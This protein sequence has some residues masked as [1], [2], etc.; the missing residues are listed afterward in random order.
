MAKTQFLTYEIHLRDADRVAELQGNPPGETSTQGSGPTAQRAIIRAPLGAVQEFAGDNGGSPLTLVAP[1]DP[2]PSG[3]YLYSEWFTRGN[4]QN[5]EPFPLDAATFVRKS[6]GWFGIPLLFGQTTRFYWRGVFVYDAPVTSADPTNPSGT[7]AAIAKRRWI[8]PFPANMASAPANPSTGE[9]TQN[10]TRD[11]GRTVDGFGIARRGGANLGIRQHTL[12][13][14]E[15]FGASNKRDSWERIY[16]RLRKLGSS[17]G[18]IWRARGSAAATSG[19][20]LVF[21]AAGQIRA[22]NIDGAGATTDIA[23]T[24]ALEIGRW[25]KLDVIL[26]FATPA[27]LGGKLLLILDGTLVFD[28]TAPAGVGLGAEQFH[29]SSE[30]LTAND[31]DFEFDI[32]SWS[33]AAAPTADGV[34]AWST[35]APLALT[36]IDFLNGSKFVLVRATG[37]AAGHANWTGD[38]SLVNQ[39][40][41]RQTPGN[42]AAD[43]TNLA[44]SSTTAQAPMRLTTDFARQIAQPGSLG[45]ASFLITHYGHRGNTNGKIGYSLDGGAAVTIDMDG[46]AAG[47][48]GGAI[49]A[50]AWSEQLYAPSGVTTP[51]VVGTLELVRDKGND[52]VV[53]RTFI[54]QAVVELVGNFGN[55]DYDPTLPEELQYPLPY[56]GP[57]NSPYPTTPWARTVSP[58]FAPV[59]IKSGTYVGNGTHTD[60]TFRAPVN[61]IWIRRSSNPGLGA[62][63]AV[64]WFSSMLGAAIGGHKTPSP[65]YMPE[66]MVDPNFTTTPAEDEQAMQTIV[67]VSGDD[68][69]SNKNGETYHYIAVSDPGARFLLNGTASAR[70]ASMPATHNLINSLFTPIAAMFYDQK[71]ANDFSLAMGFKGEGHSANQATRLDAAGTNLASALSFGA[72]TLTLR[73]DLGSEADVHM[74]YALFR[75]DDGSGDAGISRVFGMGS[76]TGNGAGA[77]DIIVQPLANRRPLWILVVPSGAMAFYKDCTMPAT[78]ALSVNGTV[79]T[80]AIT[81]ATTN[82]F[83]VGATLNSNGVLYNYLVIWGGETAGNGGMSQCGEFVPVE[84]TSPQGGGQFGDDPGDPTAP[85]DAGDSPGSDTPGNPGGGADDMDTDLAVACK[86][87]TQRLADIALGKLGHTRRLVDLATDVT[88]EAYQVRLHWAHAIE[89]TLRDFPWP[90]ATRYAVLTLLSGSTSAPVNRDWTYAYRRPTDCVFER[91]IVVTRDGAVDPTPPPFSLSYDTSGGRIFTNQASATLEYTARPECTA[92]VADPLFVEAFTWKLAQLIGPALTKLQDREKYCEEKYNACVFEKAPAVIK[93]GNPG[94]RGAADANDA[95]T[96]HEAANVAA[97]NR[98]LIA[99]GARPIKDKLTEQS[100]EAEAVR[101]IFEAELRGV[102]REFP[103]P[104]AKQYA[105]TLTHVYGPIADAD[106]AQVLAWSSTTAY[107]KGDVVKLSNVIYYALQ[108]STNQ[109]PP[110][111]T[112]WTTTDPDSANPDWLFAYRL[113]TDCVAV[114]RIVRPGLKRSVDPA[115][116]PFEVSTDARGDLLFTDEQNPTIE[117][118]SRLPGV[119]YRGDELF[120]DAVSWRIAAKL[121]PSLAQVD[122]SI[123]EQHGRGP[124]QKPHER[125]PTEAQLRQRATEYAW[126]MYL[127]AIAAAQAAASNEAEPQDTDGY[128]DPDWIRGRN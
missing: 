115:P 100:R 117:Y 13:E 19:A 46:T 79:S 5:G 4:A 24:E 80:T 12:M 83:T 63:L 16:I 99:I 47:P 108:A 17:G 58:P 77:R 74:P 103:W 40:P 51:P 96:G 28:F 75:R 89:Q 121:A 70:D 56:L 31:G 36:G 102:L 123:P 111:A 20:D 101:L 106:I 3:A 110:N 34:T 21:N 45:V 72:G 55:E 90:F 66:F 54:L 1:G 128:G 81:A 2:I 105:D 71:P 124:Q 114:R 25:Y 15:G 11:A 39:V 126:R 95:G 107:V 104:F 122:P 91:R 37:F 50:C 68:Q 113:P 44:L 33:N 86:P 57:H 32:G 85:V 18:S 97:I 65:G 119:V 118:T 112:Y 9:Q 67:R 29:A 94:P 62:V 27:G 64:R 120:Q 26:K 82:Q 35:G 10:M 48:E 60:L 76:Y 125:K 7:R 30:I 116:A 8:D 88:E 23:T 127:V 98:G 92:G 61:W 42:A 53:S 22:R 69:E 93:P 73:S 14:H 59:I 41:F 6:G 52:V 38:Y 109:Q 49:N 87:Y 84:P 78:E 43:L